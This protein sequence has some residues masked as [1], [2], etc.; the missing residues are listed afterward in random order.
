MPRSSALDWQGLQWEVG[1]EA[2]LNFTLAVG[3]VQ[4]TV[5]AEAPLVNTTSGSLGG[6][7]SSGR[8]PSICS[9]T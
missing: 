6:L 9:I 3:S 8:K 2:V 5:T 4:E 7:C 1:Q